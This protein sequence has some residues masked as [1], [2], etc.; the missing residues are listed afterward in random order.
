MRYINTLN[1]I[2]NVDEIYQ[3]EKRA[4]EIGLDIREVFSDGTLFGELLSNSIGE[5]I[6]YT[7]DKSGIDQAVIDGIVGLKGGFAK[8]VEEFIQSDEFVRPFSE[9]MA[10]LEASR[11]L[12]VAPEKS[13]DISPEM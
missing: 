13:S 4:E 5:M 12:S 7:L 11:E 9:K 3:P 10:E 1:N 6:A 8:S 2:R